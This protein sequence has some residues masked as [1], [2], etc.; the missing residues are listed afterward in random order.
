[1]ES[2]SDAGI[3]AKATSP[4][5]AVPIIPATGA[6]PLRVSRSRNR[7]RPRASRLW[8]VPTGQP[9]RRAA[10]SGLRPSSK[11]STTASRYRSGKRPSSSWRTSPRSSTTTSSADFGRSRG[12]ESLVPPSPG[13]SRPRAGRRA[14]RDLME[15]G[16]Q[17]IAHPQAPGLLDQDQERGLEGVVSVMGVAKD[18]PADPEYHRAVAM[19]QRL[20]RQL[21]R[22]VPTRGEPLEQLRVSQT[23][24]RPLVEEGLELPTREVSVPVRHVNS[25]ASPPPHP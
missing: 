5:S 18:C 9:R 24:D 2:A 25:R 22:L 1:M 15:P 17:R 4:E 12:G 13:Y 21:G 3:T 8:T 23:N 19:D 16:T 7:S 14:V 20:E 11:Q 6:S 10:C